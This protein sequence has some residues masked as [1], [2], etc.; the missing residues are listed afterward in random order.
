MNIKPKK[1]ILSLLICLTLAQ[2]PYSFAISS[3]SPEFEFHERS[4]RC[5]FAKDA[6]KTLEGTDEA[7]LNRQIKNAIAVSEKEL[8]QDLSSEKLDRHERKTIQTHLQLLKAMATVESPKNELQSF[9]QD[10]CLESEKVISIGA[11]G[12]A[13]A[14]NVTNQAV[15]FPFRFTF[16]FLRGWVTGESEPQRQVTWNEFLGNRFATSFSIYFLYRSFK[17]FS[18]SNP[19]LAAIYTTPMIDTI[20][21]RVCERKDQLTEK[22]QK[23][24]ENFLNT[25]TA[26]FQAA[27]LGQEWGASLNRTSNSDSQSTTS[28]NQKTTDENLCD[29]IAWVKSQWKNGPELRNFGAQS[30]LLLNPESFAQPQSENYRI[31]DSQLRK[32]SAT[33]IARLRNVVINLS[34]P[35]SE[36]VEADEDDEENSKLSLKISKYRRKKKRLQSLNRDYNQLYRTKSVEACRL[37]KTKNSFS[38]EE[39]QNLNNEIANDFYLER[40]YEQSKIIESAFKKDGSSLKFFNRT[41]LKWELIRTNTINQLREVLQDPTIGN[42]VFIGHTRIRS[43]ADQNSPLQELITDSLGM[44]IPHDF[45]RKLN[46]QLMS[47]SFLICHSNTILHTYHLDQALQSGESIHQKRILNIVQKNDLLDDSE[48]AALN[49]FIGFLQNLDGNLYETVQENM[50]AQQF[51]TFPELSKSRT[52]TLDVPGFNLKKGIFGLKLNQE[53]I[54]TINP[55]EPKNHFVF[56]CNLIQKDSPENSL[57]F[58]QPD[59]LQP[60][61]PKV[62]S[63]STYYPTRFLLNGKEYTPQNTHWK[64][65]E[66]NGKYQNS[67][68]KFRGES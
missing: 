39:F 10:F 65:F 22:E 3:P 4:F 62:T 21:H 43:T 32:T 38:F 29:Q 61:E 25:K 33:A 58:Y 27:S 1:S 19:A 46:P 5:H 40:F 47:I 64:N 45:F 9:F 68:I 2:V 13:H 26:F 12:I 55:G 30:S 6:I 16:H 52:C 42:I 53:L 34:P 28:W 14:S 67:N 49:G 63:G 41:R 59:T 11:R 44:I 18:A 17:L 66:T 36:T 31:Q 37:K 8:S 50:M 57:R 24:C 15:T 48:E 56:D 20:T 51:S 35:Y 54:G 60:L 23:F 7:E